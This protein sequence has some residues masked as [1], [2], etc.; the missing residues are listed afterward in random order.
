MC[1]TNKKTKTCI[2][3][4]SKSRQTVCGKCKCVQKFV[5]N[6]ANTRNS[7]LEVAFNHMA[8]KPGILK[9]IFGL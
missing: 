9:Q 6:G 2:H 5:K 7:R 1:E 3:C 8:N 4:G